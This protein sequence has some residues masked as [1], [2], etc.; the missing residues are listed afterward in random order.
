[1]PLTWLQWHLGFT[2]WAYVPTARG[3]SRFY[4]FYAGAADHFT[5]YS[6][7]GYDMRNGTVVDWSRCCEQ[8]GH[9]L[10]S[11]TLESR[12][13]EDTYSTHM[14]TT[15]A[16]Q[17]VREHASTSISSSTGRGRSMFLY[18]SYQAMHSPTQA[19]Q[20]YTRSFESKPTMH[21]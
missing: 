11:G 12:C 10:A 17:F 13:F 5:H 4:G 6:G 16:Q 8:P 14:F 7:V 2:T 20:R 1:M 3:F 21:L 15:A 9:A 18:V 19:P